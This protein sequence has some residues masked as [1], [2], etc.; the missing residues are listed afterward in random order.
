MKWIIL[1]FEVS[2]LKK[3]LRGEI[4]LA[5]SLPFSVACCPIWSNLELE[6]RGET[7]WRWGDAN[8]EAPYLMCLKCLQPA[9]P[10]LWSA[11]NLMVSQ[12]QGDMEQRDRRK[13]TDT[14]TYFSLK[15]PE[16]QKKRSIW[17]LVMFKKSFQ[18]LCFVFVGLSVGLVPLDACYQPEYGSMKL[19]HFLQYLCNPPGLILW[20][21]I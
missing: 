3:L 19:S 7:L 15:R 6:K 20:Y 12:V 8:N 21:G 10:G 18:L 1:V 2:P 4:F 13:N 14:W 17:S 9:R 11:T 16:Q 5:S